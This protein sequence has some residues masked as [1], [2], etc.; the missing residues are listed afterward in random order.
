MTIRDE[1]RPTVDDVAA[2]ERTRTTGAVELGGD[3]GSEG[4]FT[5]TTRPTATEVENLIDM[6][7]DMIL[8]WTVS[9]VD[10]I[11]YPVIRRAITIQTAVL[12]EASYF[13]ETARPETGVL[14]LWRG[15]L[16]DMGFPPV[17]ESGQMI[18]TPGSGTRGAITQ[19]LN[20]TEVSRSSVMGLV[21]YP[22]VLP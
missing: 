18:E 3:E 4:T 1:V 22:D 15:L 19:V 7:T 11:R 14:A 2:L 10:L 12:I 5:A 13:R 17:T 8:G 9:P 21:A 16:R 20:G 6:A